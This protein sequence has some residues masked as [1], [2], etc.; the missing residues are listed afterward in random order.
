MYSKT[1]LM[2]R[3]NNLAI[4]AIVVSFLGFLDASYLTIKH[5]RGEVA[6]CSLLEGCE[7]VTT[8][9]YSTIGDIPISLFGAMFYIS[10][11]AA[12]FFYLDTKSTKAIKSIPLLT[13]TGFIVSAVLVYLQIFV[14]KAICVYCMFSALTST[15]LFVIGILIFRSTEKN[16]KSDINSSTAN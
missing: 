7:V 2:K 14:L 5:F 1:E 10:V 11:L 3:L 12:A 9:K 13:L 15:L 6:P 8:S 4:A 16:E